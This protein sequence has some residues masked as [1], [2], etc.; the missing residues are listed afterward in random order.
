ME[1]EEKQGWSREEE[2]G[3]GGMWGIETSSQPPWGKSWA[4]VA[5]FRFLNLTQISLPTPFLGVKDGVPR[6][7]GRAPPQWGCGLGAQESPRLR[8]MF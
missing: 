4:T 6:R 1:Q 8:K 2:G 7:R 5:P 3:A